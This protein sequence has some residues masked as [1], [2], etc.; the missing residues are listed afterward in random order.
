MFWKGKITENHFETIK[1]L[2]KKPLKN[3]TFQL[4][5]NYSEMFEKHFFMV[6]VLPGTVYM[7]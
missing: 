7:V 6:V 4:K 5:S 3:S 1:K 2:N